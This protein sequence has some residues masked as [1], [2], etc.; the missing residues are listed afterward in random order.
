MVN[1]QREAAGLRPLATDAELVR[2]ADTMSRDAATPRYANDTRTSARDRWNIGPWTRGGLPRI[3]GIGGAS[4]A[5]GQPSPE[6]VLALW[7]HSPQHRANILDPR[8]TRVGA[9]VHI[10]AMGVPHWTLLLGYT[11]HRP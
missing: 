11:V 3:A 8:W 6:A 2:V 1:G 7:M 5:F 10:D 4:L 9:G